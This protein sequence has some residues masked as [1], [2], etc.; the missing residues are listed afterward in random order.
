MWNW[1]LN[2]PLHGKSKDGSRRPLFFICWILFFPV[3]PVSVRNLTDHPAGNSGCN[4]MAWDIL[5]YHR[6]GSDHHIISDGHARV[7]DY[8]SSNPDIGTY[9]DGPGVFHFCIADFCINTRSWLFHQKISQRNHV[10]FQ[11]RIHTWRH[12]LFS[13]Y[14]V[15]SLLAFNF[16]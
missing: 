14:H 7:D 5:S 2:T 11:G 8:I 10:L 1:Y 12:V 9:C 16:R 6:T 3:N 15:S 13:W 4:H